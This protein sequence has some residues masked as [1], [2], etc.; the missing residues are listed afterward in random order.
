MQS[1]PSR[2]SIPRRAGK[3]AV[4]VGLEKRGKEADGQHRHHLHGHSKEHLHDKATNS[5]SNLHFRLLPGT[6]TGQKAVYYSSI[7]VTR[8][9][10]SDSA[11]EQDYED[12]TAAQ[13]LFGLSKH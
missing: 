5:S 1:A 10:F 3:L 6:F 7:A 2:K 12:H 11:A 4:D 9:V 13:H 8:V